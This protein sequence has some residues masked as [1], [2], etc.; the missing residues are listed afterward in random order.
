[1][2]MGRIAVVP[3]SK[4]P[5]RKIA[6]E[7]DDVQER[8]RSWLDNDICLKLRRYHHDPNSQWQVQ[9]GNKDLL[10]K[11]ENVAILIYKATNNLDRT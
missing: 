4:L 5:A 3:R 1:M 10:S 6:R 2:S 8:N 7:K 9:T 11:K